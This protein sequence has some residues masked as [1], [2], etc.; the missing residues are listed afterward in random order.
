MTRKTG[1]ANQKICFYEEIQQVKPE[2][3]AIENLRISNKK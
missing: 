3:A 2:K 1:N